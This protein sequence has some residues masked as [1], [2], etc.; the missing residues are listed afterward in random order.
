MPDAIEA[1]YAMLGTNTQGLDVRR[2]L[3]VSVP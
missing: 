3:I 1:E 2:A